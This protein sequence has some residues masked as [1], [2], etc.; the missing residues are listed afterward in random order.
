MEFV[1]FRHWKCTVMFSLILTDRSQLSVSIEIWYTSAYKCAYLF[2]CFCPCIR[3]HANLYN[4]RMYI[5]LFESNTEEWQCDGNRVKGESMQIQNTYTGKRNPFRTEKGVEGV[6][7]IT[8]NRFNLI[9]SNRIADDIATK[10]DGNRIKRPMIQMT[11]FV[12]TSRTYILPLFQ[13]E[14]VCVACNTMFTSV[15]RRWTNLLE[16]K[17]YVYSIRIS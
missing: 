8:A 16:P 4:W 14:H 15:W 17:L 13:C 5:H 3:A 10:V 11:L 2:L 12:H 7:D 9:D 6:F 1:I